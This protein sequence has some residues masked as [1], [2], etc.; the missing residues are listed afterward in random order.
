[1]EKIKIVYNEVN[2]GFAKLV[3]YTNE[4][5]IVSVQMKS[6]DYS[7][8]VPAKEIYIKKKEK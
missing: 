5:G 4:E 8:D 1:M 3:I 6:Q 2:L 7:F